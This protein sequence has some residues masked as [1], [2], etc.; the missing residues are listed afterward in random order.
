M[1]QL[2]ILSFILALHFQARSQSPIVL[3]DGENIF[4]HARLDT[5]I[6]WAKDGNTIYLPG[7]NVN[8]SNNLTI[9]KE[10]HIIGAGH[11][12]DSSSA[13]SVT[14]ISGANIYFATGSSRSSLTGV[15]LYNDLL[16]GST[17]DRK[18][19]RLNSSHYS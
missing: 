15:Y 6:N 19:T 4:V 9:D 17:S 10:V 8:L 2:L 13:T 5:I 16:F 18:S 12:P 7:G 11:Y 3:E 1:R 14:F